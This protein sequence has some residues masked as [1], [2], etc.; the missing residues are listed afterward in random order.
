M[1]S[2]NKL[3]EI[4]DDDTGHKY[5]DQTIIEK[6]YENGFVI[7][8]RKDVLDTCERLDKLALTFAWARDIQHVLKHS[9]IMPI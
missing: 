4:L 3:K 2:W 5:Y 6:L 9:L 1:P 8:E 7:V